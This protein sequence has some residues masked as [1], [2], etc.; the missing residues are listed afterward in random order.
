MPLF[1]MKSV[2]VVGNIKLE[3][4]RRWLCRSRGNYGDKPVIYIVGR[5]DKKD[6]ERH[7]DGIWSSL[8]YEDLL[9]NF[10][11]CAEDI[12]ELHESY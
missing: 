12:T 8:I 11:G 7:P 5:Y 1:R 10:S 6:E 2:E 9:N 4:T 3:G